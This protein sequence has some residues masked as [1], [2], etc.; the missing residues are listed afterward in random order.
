MRPW[1]R[2]RG[3]AILAFGLITILVVGGLGWVTLAALRLER[4]QIDA[5]IEANIALALWRL[6]SHVF[7][8]LATEANRPYREFR[9]T[10]VTPAWS[11]KNAQHAEVFQLTPKESTAAPSWIGGHFLIARGRDWRVPYPP[12]NAIVGSLGVDIDANTFSKDAPSA[13]L[14]SLLA[15]LISN[16]ESARQSADAVPSQTV[17]QRVDRDTQARS[18]LNVAIANQGQGGFGN[19][20]PASAL[21]VIV[22]P[23]HPEWMNDGDSDHL[24]VTRTIEIGGHRVQDVTF[25][26]WNALTVSLGQEVHDL[27]PE[28]KLQPLP[29]DALPSPQRVMSALPVE[30]VPGATV[31]QNGHVGF[32]PLRIGLALSWL[33]ALVALAAVGLGGWSLLN[34]SD[35][36][37]RFVSAVTHELRTPLTTLRLYLDMLANGMVKEESQKAAYLHTLNAEADRLHLLVSNVLDFSRLENQRPRL[38]IAPVRVAELLSQVHATWQVRCQNAGKELVIA[39]GLEPGSMIQTDINLVTQILGNLI[40]NACKYSQGA[41]DVRIWLRARTGDSHA[42]WLEVEDRGS[43]VSANERRSIF[44]PFR[45]GQTEN[46]AVGGVGLGLAL[47]QRWA[48][49]LGGSVNVDVGQEDVGARFRVCLPCGARGARLGET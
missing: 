31:L 26:D 20:V 18:Q 43:G 49:L 38:T 27:L 39:D 40:D 24:I 7:T 15:R 17:Q 47:A 22:G 35:R 13:E 37:I 2:G 1:L 42:I 8:T 44:R 10:E 19:P 45:R 9:I 36:R 6:D 21:T 23:L 32:S 30:L 16:G 25:I 5:R 12:L 4:E 11:G 46:V 33:A 48:R 41:K 34:L 3:V 14:T 29:A 28:M